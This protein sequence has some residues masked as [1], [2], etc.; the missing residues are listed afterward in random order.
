MR[1]A[2]KT[3]WCLQTFRHVKSSSVGYKSKI[4]AEEEILHEGSPLEDH[5][6][7]RAA[8]WW[9][10]AWQTAVGRVTF[11]HLFPSSI[12]FL[13]SRRLFVQCNKAVCQG[14]Q[15]A[16]VATGSS[17]TVYTSLRFL[18][19]PV[20]LKCDVSLSFFLICLVRG[21]LIYPP[22]HPCNHTD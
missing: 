15:R 10:A 6:A 21:G 17:I 12:L 22:S 13:L 5:G 4:L 2:K 20:N 11:S 8:L 16:R 9:S 1:E 19:E 7:Q 3:W 14:S 18:T